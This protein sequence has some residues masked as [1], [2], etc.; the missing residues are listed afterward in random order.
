[1]FANVFFRDM[2]DFRYARC[3]A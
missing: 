3:V 1:L 2:T